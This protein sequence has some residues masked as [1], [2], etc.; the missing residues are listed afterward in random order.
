MNTD[1]ETTK[2]GDLGDFTNGNI[3]TDRVWISVN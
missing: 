1:I 2:K 3:N